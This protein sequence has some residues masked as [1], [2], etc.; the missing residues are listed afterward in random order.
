MAPTWKI[1]KEV[2]NVTNLDQ[3]IATE[4]LGTTGLD[5]KKEQQQES[6]V[7]ETGASKEA[8]HQTNS[9]AFLLGG[10]LVDWFSW[11]ALSLLLG[12]PP[13]GI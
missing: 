11:L 6:P 5:S 7:P 13:A 8:K 1:E 9:S 10:D 2:V 12:F 4:P 3:D